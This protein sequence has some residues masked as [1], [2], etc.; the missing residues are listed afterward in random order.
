M[1]NLV[2]KRVGGRFFLK[3]YEH[4]A[5]LQEKL[6]PKNIDYHSWIRLGSFPV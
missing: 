1:R 5:S 4:A 3:N 6:L 2:N